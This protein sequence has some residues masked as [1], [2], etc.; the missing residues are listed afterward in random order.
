MSRNIPSWVIPSSSTVAV[1]AEQGSAGGIDSLDLCFSVS[2]N[3]GLNSSSVNSW[4]F[5]KP[6]GFPELGDN[7]KEAKGEPERPRK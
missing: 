5:N 6:L 1:K 4:A 2:E 7:G 3:E